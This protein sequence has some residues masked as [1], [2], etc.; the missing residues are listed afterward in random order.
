MPRHVGIKPAPA[1]AGVRLT[2]G[3]W[4][5][6]LVMPAFRLSLTVCRAAPSK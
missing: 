6:A 2:I 1:E 5:E 3:S 4:N